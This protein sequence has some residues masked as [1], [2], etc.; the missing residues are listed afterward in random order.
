MKGVRGIGG[1]LIEEGR[2][3]KLLRGRN[4]ERDED[5]SSEERERASLFPALLSFE[6]TL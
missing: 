4:T 3:L 6:F 5:N 2:S 1:R